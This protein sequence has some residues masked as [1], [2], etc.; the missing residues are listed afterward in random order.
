MAGRPV[1]RRGHKARPCRYQ[2]GD[3]APAGRGLPVRRTLIGLVEEAS[4]TARLRQS[5]VRTAASA[6]DRTIGFHSITAPASWD[7]PFVAQKV[8]LGRAALTP[9]AGAGAA[10]AASRVERERL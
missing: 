8:D 1:D 9:A 3:T 4:R 6:K 5:D 10:G 2:Q 7:Q